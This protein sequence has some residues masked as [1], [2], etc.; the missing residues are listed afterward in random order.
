VAA[1]GAGTAAA[2]PR[3]EVVTQAPFSVRGAG[4]ARHE[5][6]RV[7]LLLPGTELVRRVRASRGGRFVARFAGAA[8]DRCAGYSIV[9]TGAAG[10]VA[11]LRMPVRRGCPPALSRIVAVPQRRRH[12]VPPAR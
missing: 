9:A 10:S 8:P 12:A 1:L 7:R 5:S 3:L 4:F 6:V 11:R 2:A